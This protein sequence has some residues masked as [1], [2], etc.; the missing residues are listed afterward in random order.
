MQ[1]AVRTGKP[2]GPYAK[3][4]ARRAEI[5]TKAREAFSERGYQA[6]SLRE[7]AAAV[8]MTQ[9]GLTH[10]FSSKEELLT[11]VLD[12]KD[13]AYVSEIDVDSP[14]TVKEHFRQVVE[15]NGREYEL[16][17]LYTVL[18]GEAAN[19]SHP[20]HDYFKK[21][22]SKARKLFARGVQHAQDT[23]EMDPSLDPEVAGKL[24]VAVMEG[25]QVQWQMDP[26]V[27]MLDAFDLLLELLSPQR[28]AARR[29]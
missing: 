7:I 16:L 21:R 23:G 22:F 18:C 25:L 8:G 26:K 24:I 3:T 20:A 5:I 14:G 27:K 12:E 6:S 19:A 13:R 17:R 11:A 1:P 15:R 28:P 4:P 2:R 10:H 9:P 29:R